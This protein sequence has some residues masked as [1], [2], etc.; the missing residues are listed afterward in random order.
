MEYVYANGFCLNIKV[1]YISARIMKQRRKWR[2]YNAT[3]IHT[4]LKSG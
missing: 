3:G 4:I 2:F 1:T